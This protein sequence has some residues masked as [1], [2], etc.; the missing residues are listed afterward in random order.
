MWKKN[1]KK[2]P[3]LLIMLI[4]AGSSLVSGEDVIS[5]KYSIYPEIITPGSVG[6]IELTFTNS[7][8]EVVEDL[9]IFFIKL[10]KGIVI[11]DSSETYS[12][13]SLYPGKTKSIVLK[14]SIPETT[15]PGYYVVELSVKGSY[16]GYSSS[17]RYDIPIQVQRENFLKL[18]LI[19]EVVEA[20]RIS[21]VSLFVENTGKDDLREIYIEWDSKNVVPIGESAKFYLS[22]L[23]PGE[24]K[25]LKLDIKAERNVKTALLNFSVKYMD[26]TGNPESDF[27]QIGLGVKS[28]KEDYLKISQTPAL[29]NIGT[30]GSI[31]IEIFNEGDEGLEDILLVWSGNGII[32]VSSNIK[33]VGSLGPGERKSVL[34]DV[35]IDENIEPGYYPITIRAV[36]ED[37]SGTVHRSNHTIGVKIQGTVDLVV[38]IFRAEADKLFISIANTGNAAAKNLVVY[39]RSPYGNTETFLGDMKPGDEE[40]IELDQQGMDTSKPHTINLKMIFRDVFGE[41]ITVDKEITVSV[42]EQSFSVVW[43]GV[44]T[45]ILLLLTAVL[46]WRKR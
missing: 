31:S 22:S 40:I 27:Y 34:M 17:Y 35:F 20:E 10:E 36:Y 15:L 43:V 16:L 9:S 11:Q 18:K 24:Q 7:G 14:F 33:Y 1:L 3:F 23:K 4:F 32:P 26:S 2:A 28:G 41:K 37:S 39:A 13:G 6:Y 19:P 45:A 38:T 8:S 25:E 44:G 12:L 5:A 21:T 30:E 42:H 29:L 46:F